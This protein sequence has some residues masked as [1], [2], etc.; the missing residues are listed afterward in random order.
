MYGMAHG[1]QA[2]DMVKWWQGQVMGR[3]SVA[4]ADIL[5]VGH[6]HHYRSQNVGPRL[7][8]QN[9]AMD[10]GS[11]WFRDKSGLE[12]AP[13]LISLVVGEGFDPRRELIVLGGRNDR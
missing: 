2:R 5:N 10:N 6:Y 9:P 11:A 12:S 8:I 3:C 13:G 4:D 7:F 1:H